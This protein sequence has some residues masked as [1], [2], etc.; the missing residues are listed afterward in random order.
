NMRLSTMAPTQCH[1]R[2]RMPQWA[3]AEISIFINGKIAA[4]GKPGTYQSLN[5][6]WSD[7]DTITFTLPMAP[8]LSLYT[9]MDQLPNGLRYALEYGPI[10][11]AVV[12]AKVADTVGKPSGAAA[13]K[14]RVVARNIP[15]PSAWAND[16]VTWP[17]MLPVTA[18]DIT[19]RLQSVPG[20]SLHFAIAGA[21]Q[22]QY[23]P[24]F[25]IDQEFFTCFPVLK[26]PA[27]YPAEKVGAEDLALAS[28]GAVAASDSELPSESGCTSKIIDGVIA[29][30]E[31]FPAN[32]W[33]SANTPPPHWVQVTLPRPETIGRVVINFADPLGH[34][35][36]FQGIVQVHGRNQV[37][38]D[39]TDYHGW[40]K[41]TTNIA[42]IVTDN[43]R[44]VI[45]DSASPLHPNAAQ[46]SQIQLYSV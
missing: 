21:P 5:R 1:I 35:T 10:L 45:R 15:L 7:G 25:Q 14:Q 27:S 34:P 41:Y 19:Q 30:P 4:I 29:T 37:V 36:S 28:Q 46:I 26:T 32:R 12:A 9:G 6:A 13:P 17:V 24:Y 20:K 16:E 11:L 44:L 2:I 43:F 3:V 23:V 33:H 39:V 22:Y 40:R 42:P 8:R 38:F 18:D 31:N